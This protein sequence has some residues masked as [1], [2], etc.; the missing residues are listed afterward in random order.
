MAESSMI[1]S[2]IRER[3]VM[4]GIR[5]SE[6]AR[7]AGISPSYL[8]LIEHNRRR[9]AGRTLIKL[10]DV[11]GVAPAIL[12]EGA[13]ATLIAALREAAARAEADPAAADTGAEVDRAE[14]FAGRFPGWARLLAGIDRQRQDL[15]DTVKALTDRLAHDPHLAASLHEL[16]STVTSIRSTASILADSTTLEPEWQHRFHRNINEDSERLAEGAEALVR[17]LEGARNA[18]A[19]IKAPQDELHAFLADHAFHFSELEGAGGGARIESVVARS[20]H[21]ESAAA[22][23]LARGVLEAYV[24]DARRLPM[25]GL[26]AAIETHGIDPGAIAE[27]AGVDMPAVFRRLAMMPEAVTGPVGLVVCDGSGT[28]MLRKPGL[29]FAMPRSAGACALWPLYQLLAQP[30][31][32]VR[33][34]LRQGEARVL[35]LTVSEEVA[36]AR[37]DRPALRRPHM[38]LLPDPG[39]ELAG[40]AREVGVNC[41]VCPLAD[42]AARREPSIL[43]GF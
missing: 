40:P 4:N 17:Y 9:I 35:T 36:P 33:M 30:D 13:E 26:T 5:Q 18:E 42:C 31:A 37:F 3:R 10:A 11:L 43:G 20:E 34:R 1:G 21:L 38:L 24:R 19:D 14:E 6:L 32:P 28:L 23:S 25:R 29:G 27:T 41:Q 2:R 8:N 39:A 7:R 15:E 16:I 12:S 22:R